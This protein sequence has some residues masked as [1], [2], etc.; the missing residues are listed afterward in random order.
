MERKIGTNPAATQSMLAT[1]EQL[2]SQGRL[3][4]AE[5]L[6]RQ[7]VDAS[8]K[9][10]EALHLLG[11]IAYQ[12]D[13]LAEAIQHIERAAKEAPKI[14]LYR[15]NLAEM[16]RLSGQPKLAAQEARRALAIAPRMLEPLIGL[17]AALYDLGD[18][19]GAADANRRAIA[20]A[21]D[22]AQ[23][24]C[25]LGNALHGLKHFD[26][27]IASY[28][29]AVSLA[30]K[31]P[32]YHA[33]LGEMCRLAGHI[34]E[35]IAEARRAIELHPDYPEAF[36]NLAV[37]LFDRGEYQEALPYLDRAVTLEPSF[38]QAHCYRG[39]AL[40][41]VQRLAEAEQAYR[42]A[43]D[44][45]PDFADGWNNLGT[46]LREL[47]R[48]E[49]AAA[50]YRHAQTL[51]PHDPEVL[52]NL[53]FALK[54]LDR[55][56]EAAETFR[57]ALQ[58]QPSNDKILVHYATLLIELHKIDEAFIAAQRGLEL[59]PNN[60]DAI[61]LMGRAAFER[62]EA[63]KAL[64]FFEQALALKPDLA[65]VYTHMGNALKELGRIDDAQNAYLQAIALDPDA[66]A[67]AYL[68]LSDSMKFAP[69]DPHLVRMEDLS[70]R[71]ES[72]SPKDRIQ[73]DFALGN[74]Y[75]NLKD[76]GRSFAHFRTGNAAKRAT[77]TYDE[78]AEMANFDRIETLFTPELIKAKSG[79]GDPSGRPIFILGMP[80]SGTTL[81]EQI[82]ASHPDVRGGGELT[83]LSDTVRSLRV[84]RSSLVGYPACVPL[85]DVEGLRELG[86]RY[87]E[88]LS[89]KAPTG[90]RVTDKMP[91]NYY[92][93]GLVHLM[94][95][96]AKIIHTIRDPVDNCISCFSKLF[97]AEQNHTYDLAELGRYYRRYEHLMTHWRDILPSGSFLD[98]HYEAVVADL[99]SE[100]RRIVAYCELEWD[101]RCLSFHATDRPVRTASAAQV[102]QPIYTSAIG[103]WRAYEGF[104]EP[105]LT[106][107]GR[108]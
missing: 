81:V 76:Y 93:L 70:Q 61:T 84:D 35:A 44:L 79:N 29:R 83:A 11:V 67:G 82:L 45:A 106:S 41:R 95:P 85:L 88:R 38:A 37:A 66:A 7:I 48:Y 100:A 78:K 12:S 16:Y 89:A 64:R 60:H 9:R 102:R 72:L 50:A 55:L 43:L 68:N 32:L 36:S 104:L 27:A 1:A 47:K 59:N 108:T 24:H 63:E 58:V 51:N 20:V 101:D 54:D 99:E 26:K 65:E 33:N 8:P 103:R 77:I 94:L 73:L 28:R 15:V 97:N 69:D 5:A 52:D 75:A 86:A 90:S 3:I 14:A 40:Q 57:R 10:H 91:A 107:L 74:A 25:N 22:F 87:L 19:A 98:V 96:N 21:P 92:F 42:C 71:A 13:R 23:A 56:D 62:E 17:G 2:L 49:E 6:C 31:H 53:A 4:E 30:P 39:I 80:R 46:C 105:L 18:F 34:D